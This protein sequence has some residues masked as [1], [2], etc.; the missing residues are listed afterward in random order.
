MRTTAPT[1]QTKS[2]GLCSYSQ[3][4]RLAIQWH[5]FTPGNLKEI[6]SGRRKNTNA[7]INNLSKTDSFLL[8]R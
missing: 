8:H 6:L 5:Q 1:W 2:V 3:Q 4:E 7:N